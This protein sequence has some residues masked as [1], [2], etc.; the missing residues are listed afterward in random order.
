MKG[1][2]SRESEDYFSEDMTQRSSYSGK[3]VKLNFEELGMDVKVL[4]YNVLILPDDK[5]N[6]SRGGIL[7]PDSTKRRAMSGVVV[8]VGPGKFLESGAFC[9]IYRISIGDKVSFRRNIPIEEIELEG[10]IHYLINADGVIL[11]HTNLGKN[12]KVS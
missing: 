4:G 9:E 3:M 5:E 1:H 12:E 7:L 6:Q 8:G 11:N 10:K 2:D